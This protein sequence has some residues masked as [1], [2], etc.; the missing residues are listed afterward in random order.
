M[1]INRLKTPVSPGA[2]N[3]TTSSTQVLPSNASRSYAVLVNNSDED[4]WLSLGTAAQENK[5]ILL[6]ASGG[7]YEINPSALWIGE[8]NAI[9][10]GTGNKVIVY[11]ELTT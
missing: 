8:I 2:V 9:H 7:Q 5:G 6:K 1:V 11:I 3:V 10:G 4:M